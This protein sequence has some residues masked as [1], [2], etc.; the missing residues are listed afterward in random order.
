NIRELEN[1]VERGR[2]LATHGQIEL[3]DIVPPESCHGFPRAEARPPRT[4]RCRTWSIA[5][6]LAIESVLAEVE[7][8]KGAPPRSSA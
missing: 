1:M 2:P 4:R 3:D 7:G 8:N 6:K 5:P